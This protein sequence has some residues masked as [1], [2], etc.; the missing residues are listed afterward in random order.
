MI[1]QFLIQLIKNNYFFKYV[2]KSKNYTQLLI[3]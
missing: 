3:L 1:T 2:N